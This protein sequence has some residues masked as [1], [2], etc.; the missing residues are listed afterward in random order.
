MRAWITGLALLGLCLLSGCNKDGGQSGAH[1]DSGAA[2]GTLTVLAGSEL[3]D[4]EPLLPQIEQA[5][6][7][8][9]QLKY[10][11]TLEAVEKLQN[12]EHYDLAWLANN[13]YALLTPGAKARIK[14]SERT[15]ISP[16]VLG[17][18]ASKAAALGWADPAKPPTWRDIAKAAGAGKF[19]FAMTNP[20]SSNTGFAA[21]LGLAAAVSGR[22]EAMELG[23]ID[24]KTLGEFAKAQSVTA[25]SSGWLVEVFER[26]ADSL[27]G[28]V[29]YASVLQSMNA[30]GHLKEALTLVYPKDGVI[31]ADYPLMLLDDARRA[32]Y[33]KL[34]AYLKGEEFQRAMNKAT[35]RL[36]VSPAVQP[37]T[38]A[39]SYFELS[40]PAKR[41]V[42]DGLLDAYQNTV[43]RPADSTFV[44][45]ISGSMAGERMA[46]LRQTLLGLAGEDQ[47]LSGRF[48]RMRDRERIGLL[49][50]SDSVKRQHEWALGT[51]K[52]KNTAMLQEFSTYVREHLDSDGGATS[53][54]S[55]AQKAWQEALQ[56]SSTT[57]DHVYS[58]LLMTDGENNRGISAQDFQHWIESQPTEQRRRI[59]IYAVLF[60][61]ASSEQLEAITRP[62]GGR[63]FDARKA[64]LQAA[65][66]EIR[67]YQ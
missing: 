21:V 32:D 40:F 60:G 23:D 63:V 51:D 9:L 5:T 49:E 7:L 65:F 35:N 44:I 30:S 13:K 2:P 38:A 42:I 58:L 24:F 15:M 6:G 14:A 66:K 27:D 36:P 37:A 29:N 67:G 61:E 55:A 34:I 57:P 31:T 19:R 3:S 8:H 22:G 43:R 59:R 46:Q 25:G 10:A 1:T 39:P 33:D 56:R 48:T 62:T 54:Y 12:G 47:S 20:A 16:V 4:I 28:L 64:G 26:E 50:F 18:K 41:A 45:D 52:A 53:I 17:I 11:G